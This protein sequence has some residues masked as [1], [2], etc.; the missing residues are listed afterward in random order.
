MGNQI[1]FTRLETATL[2]H[3]TTDTLLR[4]SSVKQILQRNTDESRSTRH[5]VKDRE[6]MCS[7]A[8]NYPPPPTERHYL[9]ADGQKNPKPLTGG[10]NYNGPKHLFQNTSSSPLHFSKAQ[11]NYKDFLLGMKTEAYGR[12]F[13]GYRS[14]KPAGDSVLK[15]R[16][17]LQILLVFWDAGRDRCWPPFYI[18]QKV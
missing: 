8:Y 7:R 10:G 18:P 16:S 17:S 9:P 3:C 11:G 2:H 15:S 1:Y 14:G 6:G 4:V 5:E 12:Y 13:Q